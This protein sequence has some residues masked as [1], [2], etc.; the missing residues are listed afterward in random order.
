MLFIQ[1]Q[2]LVGVVVILLWIDIK[3]RILAENNSME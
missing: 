2:H 1:Y 3:S